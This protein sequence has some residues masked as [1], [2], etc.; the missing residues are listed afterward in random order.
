MKEKKLII[1]LL[2]K[3]NE[4]AMALQLALSRFIA[5]KDENG[6]RY[7]DDLTA[8]ELALAAADAEVNDTSILANVP[9]VRAIR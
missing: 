8:L 5:N 4:T 2:V 1:C 6:I 3:D 9:R 7:E